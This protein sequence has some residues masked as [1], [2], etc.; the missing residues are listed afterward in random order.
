TLFGLMALV[1]ASNAMA[2]APPANWAYPGSYAVVQEDCLTVL[3]SGDY[4]PDDHLTSSG[5][6]TGE[7]D[8]YGDI[9]GANNG[10]EDYGD[11][12]ER[13]AA[14]GGGTY[15]PRIDIERVQIG[16]DDNWFYFAIDVVGTGMS[17]FF[18]YEIDTDGDDRGDYYVVV[19]SP[20]DLGNG[21]SQKDVMVWSDENESVGG[22]YPL[23]A[24]GTGSSQDGYE[25]EF[26]KEGNSTY[27][28]GVWAR[29]NPSNATVV[30]LAVQY[31]LLGNPQ[32]VALRGWAQKG[33]QDN[34]AFYYHDYRNAAQHGSPYPNNTNYPTAN[35]YEVDNSGEVGKWPE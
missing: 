20:K 7:C 19:K 2:A 3:Y 9:D 26:W 21:W 14:S 35:V 27:P 29:V 8:W 28:D 23:R 10:W 34:K 11:I 18:N 25:N 31:S 22:T 32:V 4:L 33:S 30:E 24:E 1:F 12:I 5:T 17:D 6:G 16:A 15:Y 13:P